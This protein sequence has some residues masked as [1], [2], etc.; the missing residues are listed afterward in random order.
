MIKRI[1]LSP[2]TPFSSLFSADQM[3]G[4]FI[5]ALSDIY[6]KEKASETV[7]LYTDGAP[8]I[9]FSSAMV[10]GYLPKPQYVNALA[11]FSNAN[12]KSNKKC[13]WLTYEDF[14]RLQ[15]DSSYLK[16][17]E[18]KLDGNRALESVQELHVSIS[19]KDECGD[20]EKGLYNV[21]YKYSKVPLVVYADVK[22]ESWQPTLEEVIDNWKIVGL[23]GDRNVGRGQ[24]D[25]TLED[26]SE[27]EKALFDYE[28]GNGFVSLSE[29]FGSDLSPVYYSIDVHAGFV[30]RKNEMNGVYRKK[31]V[32]RYLSGSFFKV[33]KGEVIRTVDGQDIFSYGLTFPVDMKLEDPNE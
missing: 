20:K 9:L 22:D 14:S 4:Q 31:P 11:D 16:T 18:L 12:E 27:A 17:K 3:W 15:C 7:R 5:W 1:V 32:I 13:N 8:P 23:G 19:R 10:D 28:D 33:G 2:R 24:F 21:S 26:L 25:I 30:G 29:S 6:G